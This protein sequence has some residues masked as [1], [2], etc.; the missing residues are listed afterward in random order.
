L[1][2]AF[3]TPERSMAGVAVLF[4]GAA[5]FADSVT[6]S[7]TQ[8]GASDFRSWML[9]IVQ[10]VPNF[11]TLGADPAATIASRGTSVVDVALLPESE[12]LTHISS[13]NS[14]EFQLHYPAYQ[15]VFDFPM[16]HWSDSQ[17]T[18]ETVSAVT[19]FG[20]FL[21]TEEQQANTMDFGLR[22]AASEP[23]GTERLFAAGAAF[24]ITPTPALDLVVAVPSRT[25][26][27]SLIQWFI[28]SR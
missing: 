28:Q 27:Q 15:F 13:L 11:Q 24:G 25:D 5:D 6:L 21:A 22:P 19:A 12:W 1:K 14:N 26:A 18:Q 9:P 17:T 20:A 23:T 10:S 4:T 7:G 3:P 16:A 2:F 8:T